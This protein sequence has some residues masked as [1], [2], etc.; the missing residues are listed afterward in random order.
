M[1]RIRNELVTLA[2]EWQEKFG[3]APAITSAISELDA[4]LL[5]GMSE[6]QYSE[7]MQSQT[8]VQKGLDFIFEGLRYQI[9]ANRP[10]GKKGS[11]VTIVPK[12]KNY[13]WDIL[14]WILYNKEYELQEAWAWQVEDYIEKFHEVKRL[15]PKDYR[16][17]VSL[18]N[19]DE[20]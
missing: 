3:V 5:V 20:L 12:A 10:S 6:F 4:A 11:R 2:L 15:A 1:S 9:K 17:G 7:F 13:D 8:A 19:I 16:N 18:L 14:I